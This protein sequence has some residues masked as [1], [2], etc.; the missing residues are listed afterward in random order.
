MASAWTPERD[1]RLQAL[2]AERRYSAIEIGTIMG[3]SRGSVIGRAGRLGFPLLTREQAT[4]KRYGPVQPR[5][6]KSKPVVPAPIKADAA[7]SPSLNLTMEE[8]NDTV[9]RFPFGENP[10]F[11]YCGQPVD[12]PSPY[13]IKHHNATRD[14]RSVKP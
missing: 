8:L 9:C 2:C 13:C 5:V 4:R 7:E 1:A 10:P 12:K 14:P 6:P 3:C 11:L